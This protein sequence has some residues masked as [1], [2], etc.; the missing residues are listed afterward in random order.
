MMFFTDILHTLP[1][2][3]D[4]VPPDIRRNILFMHDGHAAWNG[5]AT[6]LHWAMYRKARASIL[7]ESFTWPESPSF[8]PLGTSRFVGGYCRGTA[9]ARSRW[10]YHGHQPSRD[11]PARPSIHESSGRET[12]ILGVYY[13]PNTKCYLLLL[14]CKRTFLVSCVISWT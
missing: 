12:N 11:F 8:S 13:N 5:S 9:A 1:E 2:L 3:L 14:E 4:T 7:A 6:A 10:P